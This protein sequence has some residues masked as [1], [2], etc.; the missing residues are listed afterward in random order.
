MGRDSA[1]G[2][3]IV[4]YMIDGTIFDGCVTDQVLHVKSSSLSCPM[5]R[6]PAMGDR[7]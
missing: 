1:D 4:V 3:E 6:Y 5:M 7:G 2:R